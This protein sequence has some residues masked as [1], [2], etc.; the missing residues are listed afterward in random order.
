MNYW[1]Q[2]PDNVYVA[3]HRGWPNKY[4]ENTIESF[5]ASLALG[6]DQ[7]EFD[8][9]MTADGH[10]VIMHDHTVDRTTDGTG[11]VR[12]MTLAQVKS[13]DAGAKK[14][15]AFA[16]CRVPTM[17][18]LMELVKDHPTITLDLELKDYPTEGME[19]FAYESCDKALTVIDAYGFTDRVVVN[20]WSAKLNEYV[21]TKYGTKYRQHV[22]YPADLMGEHTL[23]P[24][25][26]GYCVCAFSGQGVRGNRGIG[27]REECD[28]LRSKGLRPWAGTAANNE[29]TVQKALDAGCEL[30]TCNNP[31]EVLA[32]LRAK[33]KHK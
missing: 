20:S 29:E 10:L 19:A 5:R 9:H 27:S 18:E 3:A 25:T 1:T 7:L 24:Y 14:D 26:Y 22:Y 8:V 15:P 33:G 13:L 2:S 21:Y 30:I 16:G 6:V 28:I 12:E 31:D 11:L 23:E 32:I 17:E 4:P